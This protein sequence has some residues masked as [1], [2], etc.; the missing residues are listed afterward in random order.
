[1][2]SKQWFKILCA[3]ALGALFLGACAGSPAGG[4]FVWIDVPV[5]GLTYPVDQ[6]V[7]VEGHAASPSGIERVEIWVNSVLA[8]TISSLP[9]EGDLARFSFEWMPPGVGEYTIQAVS[10]SGGGEASEA[11]TTRVI[12]GEV[13]SSDLDLAIVSVEALVAG[14]KDGV[15]FC[16][17]RVVYSNVGSEAIP[18]DF[19]I[20]FSF[21]GTPQE[22][23]TVAGGL[24]PGASTEAIFV[25][26]FSDLHYIGI[27]L[28][29]GNVIAESD[30]GNNAFAEARMCAELGAETAEPS[31]EEPV[32]APVTD[33]QF[34]AEP[35]EIQAGACTTIRWHA[36]N[37][38][39]VVFGGLDQPFDGSY[40][41]CLCGNQRYTLTVTHLD[42]TE[43]KRTV[44]ISVTGSCE[45]ATEPPPEPEVDTEP[46]DAPSPAVPDN[47]LTLSCRGSQ[48]LVWL[49]VEDKSGIA[50]YQ[51][52]VQRHSGDNNWQA[53]PGGSISVSDK[54]TSIPVEC[55]WYYR[56]RVRAVDGAGNV[57]SWSGWWQFAI[58]LS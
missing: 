48:N 1:M 2:N 47:G 12:V 38:Q 16:N 36:E 35:P 8:G 23:V 45:E 41:D 58:T 17:T 33:I 57:S 31:T 40:G 3:L 50:E 20:L 19:S 21:D 25:Y 49:P 24:T 32:L 5:S 14:D 22:T 11:D 29:S 51:V 10:F 42:G 9:M 39:S 46:P 15:P 28:D 27:N 52:E 6:S 34:W 37:V 7:Q 18:G 55:G 54:T 56:W 44:D 13:S 30:E 4:T 53:A 43:E 26:Q